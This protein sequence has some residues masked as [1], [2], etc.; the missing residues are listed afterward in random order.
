[1]TPELI[2]VKLETSPILHVIA[3]S[4]KSQSPPHD[5]QGLQNAS[6]HGDECVCVVD[7]VVVHSGFHV[8]QRRFERRFEEIVKGDLR[9]FKEIWED[10]GKTGKIWGRFELQLTTPQHQR[11]H[12]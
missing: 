12:D 6:V 8:T 7:G 2:H 5:L 11:K 1:M 9:R 4:N 10:L 3:N